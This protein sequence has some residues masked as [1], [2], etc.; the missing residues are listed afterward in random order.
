MKHSIFQFFLIASLGFLLVAAQP[1][2]VAQE[3]KMEPLSPSSVTAEVLKSKIAETEAATNLEEQTKTRL[4]ELYRKALTYIEKTQSYKTDSKTFAEARNSAPAD[5][6]KLRK[7]LEK[8]QTVSPTKTLKITEKTPLSELEQL[9]QKEKADLAA[10]EAKLSDLKKRHESLIE[11]PNAARQKLIDTR[12][13]QDAVLAERKSAPPDGELAALTQARGWALETHAR[14]LSAEI[15]MLDQE[16]L[17]HQVRFNLLEAKKDVAENNVE[18]VEA[19]V[20]VLED[21]LS[22]RRLAE[23]EQVTQEAEAVKEELKERHSLVRELAEKNLELGE[24]LKSRALELEQLSVQDDQA[25]KNSKRIEDELSTVRQKLEVAGLNQVLGK[26]LMEQR[27]ALPELAV[28]QRETGERE[29]L[30]ASSGLRQIQYGEERR[31]LRDSEAYISELT[32][33]LSQEESDAVHKELGELVVKRRELL[34]KAIANESSYLRTL[35]ELDLAQRQ[36]IDIVEAYDEFLSKRLLWVPSTEPISPSY[37]KNLHQEIARLLSPSSWFFVGK[38]LVRQLGSTPL[39]AALIIVIAILAFMRGRFLK[40]AVNSGEKVGRIRTDRLWLTTQAFIWTA[41]A[42]VPLPLLLMSIGWQLSGSTEATEFS[43]AVAD[44]LLRV[45]LH[46]IL[47]QFF[48]DVGIPGGLVMKHFRWPQD[49]VAKQRKEFRL[50][51]LL[52]L[53]SLFIVLH[54][55]NLDKT[56]YGGGL[57]MITMLV[58]IGSVGLFIFRSFTPRGGVL[59]HFLAARPEG[60]LARLRPVWLGLLLGII[61]VMLISILT[62]YLFTVATLTRNL[63]Y[64]IWMIYLLVLARGL[65][66]RWLL[67]VSRRLAYQVALERRE[68]ARAARA[69]EEKAGEGAAASNEEIM[70]IEEPEVDLAALGEDSRNLLNTAILFAGIIVLWIIW[71]PVLPAFGI[72]NDIA[73]WSHT[74]VVD[75]V[76]A[77]VPI[78]L[79]DLALAFIIGIVTAS[80]AHGLP[81]F[82]EFALLQRT[83]ITAGGRYTATTLLR[84]VIVGVGVVLFF[85][86]LGGKWSQIQWLVAALGVGIGFGL[87]EIVANFI[88]G[89]IILFERPIRVGDTVT[90][91]NVNGVV[92]RIQIRATTITNWDRQELL[93]PNKEFITT[94]LLNW[95]LSDPIIRIRIPVGIAYGSDVAKAMVLIKEAAEEHENVL[96]DP[97][98]SVSFE[99]FGDNA[100]GLFLR[101]FLPSID[102]RIRTITDLHNSINNKLNEAGIVIAF[103]QRD[104]HFDA[105]E[106]LRVHI[107]D[108]RRGSSS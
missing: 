98:P 36:L 86:I 76:E 23:A 48:V 104:I 88:S 29:K 35:G 6:K 96:D 77:V 95:S 22:K 81:A 66:I 75:G 56:G 18:F 16:L 2:A 101:A 54:S 45:S 93:V 74:D 55:F 15:K 12:R 108:N 3:K 25:R 8:K 83:S 19:H 94:Q 42:S 38:D 103:P 41:L 13:K 14:A 57:A 47:L 58:G 80:A 43:R 84:Y 33:D 34:D 30:I 91:G 24:E 59:V 37:F 72:L 61:F 50:L 39:Y 79:A 85:N 102:H 73:L 51:M 69:A 21:M 20:R 53:P 90:V 10:V 52:F 63:I 5:T 92:T 70:E 67:L 99:S 89:L 62:G 27:R 4:I 1:V 17:S 105:S 65:V 28:I 44:G 60:L 46:F 9:L 106:P 7:S 26:V 11:R 64:T 78:T 40:A 71:S 87:Q 32:K 100:L 97:A 68:A 49:S 82:L 31:R 107:D